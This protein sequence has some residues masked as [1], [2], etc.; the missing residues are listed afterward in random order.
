[1]V[2]GSAKFLVFMHFHEQLK[3]NPDWSKMTR[4]C[5]SPVTWDYFSAIQLIVVDAMALL[6]ELSVFK[7]CFDLL[8]PNPVTVDFSVTRMTF[9]FYF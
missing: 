9:P 8:V 5:I 6:S 1:M 2:M 3:I 7:V 4:G